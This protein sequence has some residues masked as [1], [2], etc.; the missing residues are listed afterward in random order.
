ML[1]LPLRNTLGRAPPRLA[2]GGA[3]NDNEGDSFA[4]DAPMP[5]PLRPLLAGAA[6]AV[7]A[8]PGPVLA[9]APSSR[10]P[11]P[12][13]QAVFDCRAVAAE[14]ERLACFERTVGALQTALAANR[15]VVVDSEQARAARREAFGFSLP[16]LNIFNRVEGG[17]EIDEATF[18]VASASRDGG[19]WTI[20]MD[21]G[22]VW[23]Q[24]QV[25]PGYMNVRKGAKAE[26]RRGLLGS[27]FMNVDGGR[28]LKVLRQR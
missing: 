18:T 19:L 14:A 20:R 23:R 3:V 15:V 12:G 9:Q 27:Y 10:G 4:G 17:E 24:T 1:V 28:A 22:Q 13:L 26:I 25:A 16:S 21:N 8:V 7:L 6:A 11:S 2:G 5:T